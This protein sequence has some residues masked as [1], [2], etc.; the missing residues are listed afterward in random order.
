MKSI[1]FAC[2]AVLFGAAPALACMTETDITI[3]NDG[4]DVIGTLCSTD[5]AAAPTVLLLHGFTGS[6]DELASDAVPE[7]VFAYTAK[8]LA[9]AGYQSLRIDFRGSGESLADLSFADTTFEGQISDAEAAMAYLADQPT[10]NVYVI[11]WSQ[12]GLVAASL[13][14]RGADLAGVA[15][16]NAVADPKATFTALFGAEV[17]EAAI[18]ADAGESIEVTLPWDAALT[19][20]GAFFDGIATLDPLAEIAS[21]GGPLFTAN[22][23]TDTLVAPASG[24][25]FVDANG[26]GTVYTADMDHVFDIFAV[27]EDLDAMIAETIAFFDAI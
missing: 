4:Q 1:P 24:Q 27:S 22:G 9:A 16:W 8:A 26:A 3:S 12:G 14:G 20:N 10:E 2:A 18:A 15:L 7:G 5:D 11:G 17:L 25:D 23:M 19:L 13:A 21:Y 6:R